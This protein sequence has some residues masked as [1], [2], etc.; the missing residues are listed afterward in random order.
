[1]ISSTEI[2]EQEVVN[3]LRAC[4]PLK[5]WDSECN[6]GSETIIQTTFYT[7]INPADGATI[8]SADGVAINADF[9]WV[10]GQFK[11]HTIK[12][13]YDGNKIGREA[14]DSRHFETSE[15][16]RQLFEDILS[17]KQTVEE[18]FGSL[19]NGFRVG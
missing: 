9:C 12:V 14:R 7:D 2:T 11:N 16:A 1:M 5:D 19:P 8:D 4:K 6:P 18:D 17:A 10:S 3:A 15:L 13:F